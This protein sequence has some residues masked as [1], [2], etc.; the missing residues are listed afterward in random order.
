M[1]LKRLLSIGVLLAAFAA[2]PTGVR[3]QGGSATPSVETLFADAAAKERA[4]RKVLADT[5]PPATVLKAVRTVVADFENAVRHYPASGYADD[6]LWRGAI[7]SKDG[8]SKF[9]EAREQT[10]AIRLLKSLQ[11]RYPT[12]RLAKAAGPEL[13]ALIAA[14]PRAAAK[15]DI[16]DTPPTADT[17]PS[18]PPS[19]DSSAA[20]TPASRTTPPAPSKIATI[21]AIRRAPMGNA[22]RVVIELDGEVS[23]H[24]ERLDNP[25]RVFV[26]LA[27]TRAVTGLVDQTL[28][29]DEDSDLV[30]QIRIGRHPKDT[31][32]VVLETAGIS[33]YS[34]YPLY[35]PFRLVIDCL[36]AN[37]EDAALSSA[38][39]APAGLSAPPAKTPAAVATLTPRVPAAAP[40]VAPVSAKPLTSAAAHIPVIVK[41]DLWPPLETKR[42]SL[43]QAKTPIVTPSAAALLREASTVRVAKPVA[44]A[45]NKVETS[46]PPTGSVSVGELST[47]K[48]GE[49]SKNVGGGYSIAR[50]LGLT[51][52]RIVIDPGHGGHD[53][54]ARAG[55]TTE[56]ELVLDIALKLEAE[57]TK[58]PGV[59]VV[60]TRRTDDFVPLVERTA[61][62][63]REN[64][65]LFLSIHANANSLSSARGVETYFLNFASNQSAAAVAARENA[66]SGQAMSQLPDVIKAIALNDKRDESR[67]FATHVQREMVSKLRPANKTL[68]DLGVK[69]APFVVLIGAAMPS[70][71]AEV[72][73]LTNPQDARLLKSAQYRQRIVTALFE[74]VRKYQTALKSAPSLAGAQ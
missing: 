9:H 72:S 51:V 23:F 18:V 46:Q 20:A 44:T 34:V 36:R 22:V 65:D 16:S 2:M 25:A 28:R 54:G 33:S 60:L 45:V 40:V 4:V 17:P 29:F 30:R 6:A 37:P 49:P 70:A 71:L 7:L 64:A 43:P 63:N 69:Q 55:G 66:V 58:L 11:A 74:A 10:T 68:R 14:Q 56:A 57:L 53:P 1:T 47:P 48:L 39:A 52:S 61:I 38:S 12:S 15:S 27:A 32:R 21:K 59:E 73:F 50:Q 3:A 42:R 26:D 8:F 35:S 19:S 62:A 24:D 31:T 67:D 13:A 41:P 5:D